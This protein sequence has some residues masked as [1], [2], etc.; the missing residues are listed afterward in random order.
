MNDAVEVEIKVVH[1]FAVWICSRGVDR[2]L[3]AI[4]LVGLLLDHGGD[5]L[6]VLFMEPSEERWNTHCSVQKS[7]F[8]NLRW[9]FGIAMEQ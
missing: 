9:K 3:A 6:R 4:H 5:N 1:L 7:R 2:I 8:V